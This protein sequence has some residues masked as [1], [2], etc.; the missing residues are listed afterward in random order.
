MI[1][2]SLFETFEM[3]V[4]F[5]FTENKYG[6]DILFGDK[7]PTKKVMIKQIKQNVPYDI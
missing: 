6:P 2:Y 1:E 4:F 5:F 3:A 7:T